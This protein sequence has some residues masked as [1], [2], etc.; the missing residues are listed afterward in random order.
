MPYTP[1]RPGARFLAVV[2]IGWVLL[3]IA[4]F[5]YA[6]L[7]GIPALVA[8]PAAAAFLIEFPFYLLP[9]FHPDWLKRPEFLTVS[10][11]LPYLIYSIPTGQFRVSACLWLVLIA[12]TLSFWYKVLPKTAPSDLLFIALAA[13]L[14]VAKVFDG[15]YTSPIPKVPFSVLG[16]IMLIRTCAIAM[17]AIRGGV[18]AEF[19]FMPRRDEA[20]AGLRWFAMM[21]PVVAAS[22]WAVGLWHIK[23]NPNLPAGIATFFG[24]LWVTALSEEFFF[25]GL[26]QQWIGKWTGSAIAAVII[27]SLLFGSVHL[28]WNHSFPN[29]RFATVATIFGLFCGLC[30]R[31]TRSVQASMMTHA[32]GATLY[33][34]FFTN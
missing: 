16:H 13:S 25:R 29:W 30:F 14:Y 7:K 33:R 10:C 26:L 2:G 34:V 8:L 18:N 22:L 21:L 15:I 6:Q 4:A 5:W 31:Q 28:G 3:G 20:V 1:A 17:L 27:A 32:L 19:R 23:T 9:G 11:I 24:I 12:L